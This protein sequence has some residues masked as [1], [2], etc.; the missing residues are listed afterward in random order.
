MRDDGRRIDLYSRAVT[1]VIITAA[2]TLAMERFQIDWRIAAVAIAA[3]ALV[4]VLL[5]DKLDWS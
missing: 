1:I 3:T 4:V 2:V 5:P